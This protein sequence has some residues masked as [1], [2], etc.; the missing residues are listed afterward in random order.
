MT[1]LEKIGGAGITQF[2]GQIVENQIRYGRIRHYPSQCSDP[3]NCIYLF[4][5][6]NHLAN[7]YTLSFRVNTETFNPGDVDLTKSY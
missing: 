3:S 4:S 6:K 1:D 7:H 2:T 5:F